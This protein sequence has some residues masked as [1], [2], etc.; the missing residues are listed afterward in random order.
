MEMSKET[1]EEWLEGNNYQDEFLKY[2]R[3]RYGTTNKRK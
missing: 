2:E 1:F 3:E